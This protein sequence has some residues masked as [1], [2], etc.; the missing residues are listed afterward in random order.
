MGKPA[1]EGR[2]LRGTLSESQKMNTEMH[3]LSNTMVVK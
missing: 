2:M 3:C 1:S